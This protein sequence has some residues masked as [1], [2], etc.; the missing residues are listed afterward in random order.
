LA[1]WRFD[2]TRPGLRSGPGRVFSARIDVQPERV[3]DQDVVV[4]RSAT[5]TSPLA[6][7][8]FGFV[9]V[10]LAMLVWRGPRILGLDAMLRPLDPV[11]AQAIL[12]NLDRLADEPIPTAADLAQPLPVHDN[13]FFE[14]AIPLLP[15]YLDF[16]VVGFAIAALVLGLSSLARRLARRLVA[17]PVR[18]E[19]ATGRSTGGHPISQPILVVWGYV[20][21]MGL[22]AFG[23]AFLSCLYLIL[24]PSLQQG[25]LPSSSPL[26]Q[27][28][29]PF[30]EAFFM[31]RLGQ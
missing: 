1:A 10:G 15:H 6:L 13:I 24:A 19:I 28:V 30:V 2:E 18:S 12:D 31:G 22:L 20:E 27:L 11:L 26:E 4:A 7:W 14:H 5:P 3:D 17:G 29:R 9:I 23:L 25:R 21:T 16:L 8:P